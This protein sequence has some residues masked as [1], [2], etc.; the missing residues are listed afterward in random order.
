MFE[1]KRVMGR[2]GNGDTLYAPDVTT[3]ALQGDAIQEAIYWAQEFND[4]HDVFDGD[5]RIARVHPD[6][7]IDVLRRV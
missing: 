6:G 3:E 4:A 7:G 1:I 2:A 5:Q